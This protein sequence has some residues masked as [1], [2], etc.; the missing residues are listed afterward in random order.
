MRSGCPSS[1]AAPGSPSRPTATRAGPAT[2]PARRGS[3]TSSR[4]PG[5]IPRRPPGGSGA[6]PRACSTWSDGSSAAVGEASRASQAPGRRGR[7]LGSVLHVLQAEMTFLLIVEIVLVV[8]K[9]FAFVNSLTYPSQAYAAANKLTKPAW[10][11]GLGLGL[12][13]Q[14]VM[15]GGPIG[16]INLAFTVGAF[17]Y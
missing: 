4:P 1:C 7:R 11:I 15:G 6:S 3:S 5:P 16:I 17:V 10:A 8:V 13:V 14:L 12:V 2:T 9:L